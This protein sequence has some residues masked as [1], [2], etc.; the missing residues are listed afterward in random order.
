MIQVLVSTGD[1]Q[2]DLR[3]IWTSCTVDICWKERNGICKFKH[4]LPVQEEETLIPRQ[5]KTS[6]LQNA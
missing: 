4:P 2:I 1:P 6:T 3:N 5:L